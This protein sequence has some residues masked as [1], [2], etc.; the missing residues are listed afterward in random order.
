MASVNFMKLKG[1]ADVARVLRH[2]DQRER[3]KREHKNEHINKELTGQNAQMKIRGGYAQSYGYYKD[4][5]KHLDASTNKNHRKDR[6]T[7][8]ALEAACPEG[9]DLQLFA[10]IVGRNISALYGYRNII[11]FYVHQDE[12]HAYLDHG[13]WKMS[14]NHVH[15]ILI[16][17]IDGQLRGKE[18]S[19]KKMMLQLNQLIDQDCRARGYAFLT[20]AGGRHKSVEELKL[21]SNAEL[22]AYQQLKAKYERLR[23]F[24]DDLPMPDNEKLS[25][26]QAFDKAECQKSID[27]ISH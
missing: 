2:C 22:T 24:C 8:F 25:V 11:N 1:D 23:D 20:G 16:P 21:E 26:L 5:I 9:M 18:F 15:A 10:D 13:E 6:V 14:L 3:L 17:E 4:R 27:D 12:R 7:G 19:S